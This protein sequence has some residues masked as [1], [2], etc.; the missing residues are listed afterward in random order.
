MSLNEL[1]EHL[2]VRLLEVARGS[3]SIWRPEMYIAQVES[4]LK[5]LQHSHF[6]VTYLTSDKSL[7]S[8]LRGL[9]S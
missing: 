5:S 6:L 4:R 2:V 8:T 3:T 1:N 7:I 9:P